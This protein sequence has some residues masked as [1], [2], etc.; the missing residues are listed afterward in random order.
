MIAEKVNNKEK[1]KQTTVNIEWIFGMR[2]DIEPNLLMLDADTLVYPAS[3]HIVI[4]NHTRKF[5]KSQTQQ[6]IKGTVFSNGIKAFNVANMASMNKKYI[7]VAE[8]TSEGVLV[9]VFSLTNTQGIYNKPS[10]AKSL[11][12]YDKGITKVYYLAFSQKDQVDHNLLAMTGYSDEPVLVLW[13]WGHDDFHDQT[14]FSLKLPNTP[15]KNLQVCFQP[16]KNES[17]LIVSDKFFCNFSNKPMES[18]E[19]KFTFNL[20]PTQGNVI[21]SHCWMLDNN[22]SICTDAHVIIFDSNFKIIQNV[23]T[24]RSE[25]QTSIKCILPLFDAFIGVGENRRFELYERKIDY[26]EK[27]TEKKNFDFIGGLNDKFDKGG[28]DKLSE[29]T[30]K[31]KLF[32]F[33]SV[34]STGNTLESPV[35]ATTTFNDIMQVN[36]NQKDFEASPTRHL[37]SPFHSDSIEGMDVCINKPYIITCSLDKTLRVWDYVEK[38]MTLSR[39]CDDEMYSVAYHP[40]GMHAV[41]SFPDKLQ[42]LHIFYDEIGNMTQNPISL[43]S[44]LKTKDV[45]NCYKF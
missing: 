20:K 31:E 16:H 6:F 30:D 12:L 7:S 13:K 23:D 40:N 1:T 4:F 25:D 9:R 5:P 8:E 32:S 35:L 34:C 44:N 41:V 36:I 18:F 28:S 38:L 33:I 17:I 2:K 19:C 24:F 3:H 39:T 26:Y 22:F 27:T 43:K 45:R 15:Y 37:I 14:E 42:P 29:Q 21:F 11:P 10:L